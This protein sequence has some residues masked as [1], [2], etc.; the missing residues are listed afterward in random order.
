[1]DTDTDMAM[2]RR[3][4]P[5][6]RPE[7]RGGRVEVSKLPARVLARRVAIIFILGTLAAHSAITAVL[8]IVQ[9]SNPMLAIRM[10]SGQSAAL[11]MRADQLF[12]QS[13]S[14]SMMRQVK[15]LS[16][17]SLES[18]ALNPRAIRLLGFASEADRG[19]DLSY[20]LL[21]LSE[22]VSRRDL[23]GQLWLMEKSVEMNDLAAAL[24][25]YDTALRFS[26]ESRQLLFPTLMGAL[27]EPEIQTAFV[28]YVHADPPWMSQFV[29][30]VI[31][32]NTNL[33]PLAHAIAKARGLPDNPVGRSLESQ[34]LRS[35]AGK[36][37]AR[38]VR[39]LY[40]AKMGARR[41]VFTT[42]AFDEFSADQEF[43]PIT[44]QLQGSAGTEASFQNQPGSEHQK[45]LHVYASSGA[46]SVVARKLLFL[47]SGA[48]TLRQRIE[49]LNYGDGASAK[50]DV[51]C[52]DTNGERSI[53]ESDVSAKDGR[54]VETFRFEVPQ[55]CQSQIMSLTVTGGSGQNGSEFVIRSLSLG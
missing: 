48:Y 37:D 52:L 5:I 46:S 36:G 2:A 33:L 24:R 34:L 15:L 51:A 27:D 25:H 42:V 16:L 39:Q 14:P 12:A 40:L 43:A 35:V 1:M 29:G 50:W 32:Q 9:L 8:N 17:R 19:S 45:M 30:Y 23:G 13:R 6:R 53:I 4:N 38:L 18:R 44:W 54:P 21:T 11:A 26:V 31:G 28:D 7:V 41:S 47:P 20:R 22:K 49:L 10:A 55:S 3:A